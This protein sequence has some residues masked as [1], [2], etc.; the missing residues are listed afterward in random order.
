MVGRPGHL[1]VTG[2]ASLQPCEQLHE[3]N[4]TC[5]RLALRT[6]YPQAPSQLCG[7]ED[8]SLCEI[9]SQKASP[10]LSKRRI[11]HIWKKYRHK[12]HECGLA[13]P[14]VTVL[15]QL[16]PGPH[17]GGGQGWPPFS[18]PSWPGAGHTEQQWPCQLSPWTPAGAISPA[19][20]RGQDG[21]TRS[22]SQANTA[23]SEGVRP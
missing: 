13:G 16:Q 20:E 23:K 12:P 10:S 8:V 5:H 7:W 15:T 9:M 19:G 1:G 22:C 18:P 4:S 14:E 17:G 2:W 6:F 21:A 3:D 11:S